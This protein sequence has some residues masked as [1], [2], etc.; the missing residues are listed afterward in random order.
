MKPFFEGGQ[1]SV[2]QR[3]PKARG[4]KRYYKLVDVVEVV[5]LSALEKD[6]RI[7]SLVNK[8][9]LVDLG[10]IHS[11]ADRVKVLG[12][13]E[14]SKSLSFEGIELFSDAAKAKIEK[15]GGSIK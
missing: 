10:Y 2:V 13:G 14:L 5:N 1:T 7:T 9:L 8:D 6:V 12:N 11:N 3:M 15:A 4:F